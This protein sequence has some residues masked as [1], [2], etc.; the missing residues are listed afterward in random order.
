MAYYT[1]YTFSIPPKFEVAEDLLA[2]LKSSI[3]F[4]LSKNVDINPNQPTIA[5]KIKS[6]S[7]NLSLLGYITSSPFFVDNQSGSIA[8]RDDN[9]RTVS[10]M[11]KVAKLSGLDYKKGLTWA[12]MEYSVPHHGE[13]VELGLETLAQYP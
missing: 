13:I 10:D 8:V 9:Q 7:S 5:E 3:G 4:G 6:V 12:V 11:D 1:I 2:K